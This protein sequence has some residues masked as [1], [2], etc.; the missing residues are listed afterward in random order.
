MLHLQLFR[1]DPLHPAVIAERI[2][3]KDQVAP[4]N[5]QCIALQNQLFT[6]RGE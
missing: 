5:V 6:L 4:F 1:C 2:F 3:F